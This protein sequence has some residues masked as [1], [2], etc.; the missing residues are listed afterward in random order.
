MEIIKVNDYKEMSKQ[1]AKI[2]L[3]Q[4]ALKPD[5]SICFATGSTPIGMYEELIKSKADFSQIKTFNL[6]EYIGLEQTHP[7]SYFYFMQENLF[8]NINVKPENINFPIGV[9]DIDSNVKAYNETLKKNGPLDFVIL[10]IGENGHIA[11]NEP[12]CSFEDET[13]V[14]NLTE[15]TISANSRFFKNM[16]EVPKTAISMGIKSILNS[17]KIIL[18]ASGQ[19]KAQAIYETVKG[20]YTNLCPASSLQ[21]HG[22]VTIIVDKEAGS[23]I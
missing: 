10:G 9:G 15:N 21:L 17:K 11:F 12:K 2:L 13:R 3:D 1:A 4:I 8:K 6:D 18:L 7:K 19:K 5:S 20:E 22:N 16:D 23:K 14:V